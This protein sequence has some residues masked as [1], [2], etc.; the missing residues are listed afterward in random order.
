MSSSAAGC[1][2][3]VAEGRFLRLVQLQYTRPPRSEVVRQWQAVE[4]C[5]TDRGDGSHG[6]DAVAVFAVVKSK[7]RPPQLV[8]VK[9]FRPP[10]GL[11]TIELPAGLVDS[12]EDP[13]ETA[14]RELREETGFA[15]TRILGTGGRQYLSPGLTNENI[16]TVFVEVDG[17]AYEGGQ[18]AP[19]ALEED[20]TIEVALLPL[21][22]D[23]E[24][25]LLAL[26]GQGH[27]VWVGLHSIAQGM[28]LGAMFGLQL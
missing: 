14:L 26:E 9:Q 24:G 21:D 23:L 17:D 18:P 7:T 13:Q 27:P 15:A 20:E 11:T 19:Q 2:E 8:V 3:V 5:T 1:M 22:A 25:R 16:V 10:L 12:G 4:R 28:K 6:I